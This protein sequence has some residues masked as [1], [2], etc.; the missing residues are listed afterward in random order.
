MIGLAGGLSSAEEY[1][2]CWNSPFVQLRDALIAL[3]VCHVVLGA[4]FN[5]QGFCGGS[6]MKSTHG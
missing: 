4:N 6:V 1:V 5:V 3:E 2:N